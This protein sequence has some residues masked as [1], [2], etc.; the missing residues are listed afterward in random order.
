M[1]TLLSILV[2]CGLTLVLLQLVGF[3]GSVGAVELLLIL[4]VAGFLT[5]VVNRGVAR[6]RSS[7]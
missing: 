4:L 6:R 5:V 2:F 7:T 1:G 3:A